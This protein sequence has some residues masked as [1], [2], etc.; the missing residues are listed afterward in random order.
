MEFD[1]QVYILIVLCLKATA[2]I[3]QGESTWQEPVSGRIGNE[4]SYGP[5]RVDASPSA[6]V[7]I[8]VA[9]TVAAN[10]YSAALI[11]STPRSAPI[12][13]VRIPEQSASVQLVS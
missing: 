3:G 5:E 12:G 11:Q 1:L 8:P 4:E 10:A 7:T 9:A 6:P 2:V 13:L